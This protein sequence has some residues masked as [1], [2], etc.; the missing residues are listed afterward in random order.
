MI[1]MKLFKHLKTIFI[2]KWYVFINMCRCGYVWR[3]ITHDMSKFS[4]T[5]LSESVKYY[6]GTISPIDMCKKDKGYSN[7]WLHHKGR[8]KH[9]YEYWV[10][11]LDQGGKPIEMPRKYVIELICDWIAAGKTYAHNAGKKFTYKDELEYVKWK[12][13]SAKMHETTKDYVLDCFER[14]AEIENFD[15]TFTINYIIINLITNS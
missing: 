3:G 2:H 10:D 7:A 1:I 8:N 5:E 4:W 13:K 12:L 6:N 11:Y 15:P 9:H 14:Y